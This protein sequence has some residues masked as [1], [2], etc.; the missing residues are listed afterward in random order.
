[1]CRFRK[2]GRVQ[3]GVLPSVFYMDQRTQGKEQSLELNVLAGNDWLLS[4]DN[5]QICARLQSS[6]R[7]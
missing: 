5:Q 3:L 4:T 1:M 6:T 7:D 2:V